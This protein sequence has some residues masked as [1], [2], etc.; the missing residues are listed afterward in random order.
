MDDLIR[1]NCLALNGAASLLKRELRGADIKTV[2]EPTAG[3]F[4]F[5][6]LRD[7]LA[8]K[9][10]PLSLSLSLSSLVLISLCRLLTLCRLLLQEPTFEAE[11]K[12][13]RDLVEAGVVLN[14]GEVSW[15]GFVAPLKKEE[16]LTGSK[17]R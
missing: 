6:D 9:F 15:G 8:V 4:F 16:S 10:F 14:A 7:L 12:L 2:G 3:L 1:D 17:F 11:R 13:W 5:I